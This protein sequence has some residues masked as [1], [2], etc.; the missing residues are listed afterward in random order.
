M[1][2]NQVNYSNLG[3]DELHKLFLLDGRSRGLTTVTETFYGDNW[4]IFLKNMPHVTTLDYINEKTFNDYKLRLQSTKLKSTSINTNLRGIRTF[5]NWLINHSYVEPFK[6]K[7]IKSQKEIKEVYTDDELTKI[8]KRP[9]RKEIIESYSEYRNWVIVNY[10]VGTGNRAS[11]II[12]LLVKDLSEGYIYLRHTKNKKPQ[13]VPLPENLNLILKE[14]IHLCGLEP[15]EPMFQSVYGEKLTVNALGKA[16]ANYNNSRGV[17]K[18]GLHLF[19]H[20]FVK[21]WIINGGDIFTL[22]KLMGHSDIS[23]LEE[24]V[25]LYSTEIKSINEEFNPLN[26]F[27]HKRE[28]KKRKL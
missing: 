11:S 15:N 6:M 27:L 17:N 5:F 14:Y 18:R 9:T 2:K 22:Q 1:K 26:S 7:L 19:R 10:L 23:I 13:I 21:K 12:N 8:L 28:Q 24:Y 16:I 20:T 25:N 3:L 4:K